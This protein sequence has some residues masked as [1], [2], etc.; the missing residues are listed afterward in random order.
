[1]T[2]IRKEISVNTPLE[3]VWRHLVDPELLAAWLMRN[4]FSGQ[5]GAPFEF[6]TRPTKEWGGV[7]RC[8]LVKR[9]PAG[10]VIF[11]WDAGGEEG[12]TLVS[13]DLFEES[14][15]TQIR[16]IHS[17]F[18]RA[19]SDVRGIIQ[20]HDAYWTDHLDLLARQVRQSESDEREA[21]VPID[22]TMFDLY[23]S[24]GAEPNKV[25]SAWSTTV[26]MESF[27]VEMMRITGPDGRQRADRERAEPGDRYIWRWPTGRYVRGQYLENATEDEVRFTFGDSKV[28]VTS[29]PYRKGTLLRLRQFDIPDNEDARMHI[30]VNCRAAWVYFLSVLKTLL[31]QGIDGRDM[32]RETGASF[33]TFFDPAAV[34][35]DF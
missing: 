12:E 34:G 19:D 2:S 22:W 21:P 18:E 33:S 9:E 7:I 30:H 1:M 29:K 8:R 16:L 3:A 6:R 35:V 11:T 25:L 31:E 5:V 4:N 24:I 27:F 32:T 26:G 20:R 17:N 13:I 14:G 23:V 10:K 28:C 15:G